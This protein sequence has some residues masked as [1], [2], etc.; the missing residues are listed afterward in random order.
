MDQQVNSQNCAPTVQKKK[1]TAEILSYVAIGLPALYFALAIIETIFGFLSIIPIVSYMVYPLDFL[2]SPFIDLGQFLTIFLAP[3]VAIVA[4]VL[5]ASNKKRVMSQEDPDEADLE[6]AKKGFFLSLIATIVSFAI[7][8]FEIIKAI[9]TILFIVIVIVLTV[10][11]ILFV[12]ILPYLH[13]F[14]A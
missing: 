14:I 4:L 8:I 6:V 2:T 10:T 7:A 11:I 3:V 1:T 9:L 12:S 5:N 13:I